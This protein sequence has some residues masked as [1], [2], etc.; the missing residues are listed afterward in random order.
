MSINFYDYMGRTHLKIFL[1]LFSVFISALTFYFFT[2]APT[3]SWGDSADLAL[4]MVANDH[5]FD[6][7]HRAYN[8]YLR[9]GEFFQYLPFGD[10]GTRANFMSAF[11]GA[12]TVTSVAYIVFL[13]T[14]NLLAAVIGSL[15]LLVAHTF[16]LLSVIAE[17]YTFNAALIFIMFALIIAWYKYEK[18]YLFILAIIFA[19]F[20]LNHHATGLVAI[21]AILPLIILKIRNVS[22]FTLF[23]AVLLLFLFSYSYWADV[24]SKLSSGDSLIKSLGLAVSQNANY[25]ISP[26]REFV[27]FISYLAYNFFGIGLILA[28]YGIYIGLRK[29]F[30]F[31]LPFFVWSLAFIIAG[32]T[33][34]I[35]DKFNIYV[36]SYPSFAIAIGIGFW[37]LINKRKISKKM[38]SIIIVLILIIPPILYYLTVQ[39]S[40]NFN[41]DLTK[42]RVAPYR[43]NARYFLFP[44]KNKDYGPKV[45]AEKAIDDVSL[46]GV[47][48]ADYTL[49]RP[50]CY[51][52]KIENIRSDVK[53]LWV[54]RLF[55]KDI[56]NYISN[57]DCSVDV[58]LASDT[59]P[60][61]Y[62]LNELLQKF[63]VVKQGSIFKVVDR[64]GQHNNK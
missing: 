18:D 42:A 50:L 20:S 21:A 51:V 32:I 10:A 7:T 56:T 52:Q 43:D 61:Y 3:I 2:L 58:F 36:L 55:R 63:S 31:V 33:S 1:L 9:I 46:N 40:H 16:W 24:V 38:T 26:F 37:D 25:Q 14:N 47:L 41:I 11:F 6:G 4:R 48:I 27:K 59:P 60:E 45:F 39:I 19:S 34:S 62:K 44:P 30:F 5:M 22:L 54:E 53:L 13:I 15:S 28:F 29:K 35:P 12:L 49:W 8:L 23:S 64:C 57:I 17:V